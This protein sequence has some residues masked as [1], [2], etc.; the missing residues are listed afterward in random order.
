MRKTHLLL[1]GVICVLIANCSRNRQDLPVAEVFTKLEA[2]KEIGKFVALAFK[3]KEARKAILAGALKQ[4][5]GDYS[6]KATTLIETPEV[7]TAARSVNSNRLQ[8]AVSKLTLLNRGNGPSVFYPRAE[9]V[10]HR[11]RRARGL[12]TEYNA[13]KI[14]ATSNR[15]V[16]SGGIGLGVPVY[17]NTEVPEEPEPDDPVDPVCSCVLPYDPTDDAEPGFAIDPA[18]YGTDGY[19]APTTEPIIVLASSY[20]STTGFAAGYVLNSTDSSLV[21]IGDV[22]EEYAWEHDV[23]VIVSEEIALEPEG[24]PIE[25][26]GGFAG[27]SYSSSYSP[28]PAGRSQMEPEYGGIIQIPNLG[29]VEGWPGGQLEMMLSVISSTGLTIKENHKFKKVKRKYFRDSK[30]YDYGLFLVNWDEPNIGKFMYEKW[31][32]IDGSTGSEPRV[33]TITFPPAC[34]TCVGSTHNITTTANSND[35]QLGGA[36]IA[37]SDNKSQ[38]YNINYGINIKRR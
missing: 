37:F 35:E 28:P 24:W 27:N 18:L 1:L 26:Y 8:A 32:E 19:P 10:Q 14:A 36:L 17:A 6:V 23:L 12:K 25:N 16:Y 11:F 38:V 7:A 31:T 13:P 2:E 15:S 22:A 3:N 34:S 5:T 21:P 30:W 33:T 29:K 9:T 4:A 20:D